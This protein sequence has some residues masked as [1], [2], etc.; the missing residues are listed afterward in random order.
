MELA[1]TPAHAD[2]FRDHL[3]DAEEMIG[4]RARTTLRAMWY[5]GRQIWWHSYWELEVEGAENVPAEGPALLCANHS[6]HLDAPAILAALSPGIALRTSTAAAKDVFGEQRFKRSVSQIT[7]NAVTIQRKG[8]FAGGL[9]ALEQV[10]RER[11]PLILFPEGRRSPDGS[12]L[13]FKD[14]AAMLAMRTGAPII[15]IHLEGLRE[16]LPRGQHLPL[17]TDVR[18]QFG[19]PID[20]SPY[21]RAV[22]ADQIE[23][24]EAY[25][26]LTREVR[27]AVEE[28]GGEVKSEIRIP[29]TRSKSE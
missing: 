13:P 2:S 22:A 27:R 10:L 24:R 8:E 28:M 26:L 29:E 14:G 25:E 5:A 3:R 4:S 21:Q 16:S 18:V 6:S 12:L 1:T 19:K 15:P 9:R 11:R 7:T 23:R 17:P 20:P